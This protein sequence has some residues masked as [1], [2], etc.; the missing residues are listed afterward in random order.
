MSLRE[1]A[2]N[3]ADPA[4]WCSMFNNWK[5]MTLREE[6]RFGEDFHLLTLPTWT[7]LRSAYGGGPEIPF[8]Q[9]QAEVERINED[10]SV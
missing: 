5:S 4:E 7:K 8:F 6:L 2:F 10:G 1:V 9:Y 3:Y